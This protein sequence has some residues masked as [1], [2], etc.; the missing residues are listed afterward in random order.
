MSIQVSS[1]T[2]GILFGNPAATI[3]VAPMPA[4][5]SLRARGDLGRIGSAIGVDLPAQIGHRAAGD[6]FE[7]IC[8]G[9]D[10]WTLVGAPEK[11]DD[12]TAA[13]AD[14]Y[15]EVPHSLTD[16]SGREVTF[17]IE[18]PRVA[19]LLSIAC[20]RDI[21]TIA[22]GEG[23]RTVFDGVTV[24][25]WCDTPERY[26]MDVWNSFAAFLGQTLQTGCK[27]LAA[28]RV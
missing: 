21:R 28:E 11:A 9:P 15:P 19:E 10:E 23:R 7:A 17:V 27:E 1:L 20:P 13:L 16:I 3:A 5:F 14:I 8:L 2:P 24:V 26:R 12:I 22:P 4:R 6:G 25:I 18:G